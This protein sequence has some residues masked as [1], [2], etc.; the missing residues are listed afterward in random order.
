MYYSETDKARELIDPKYLE[1]VVFDIGSGD[2]K[3]KPEAFG[4]DGRELNGVSYHLK[5]EDAIYN[6]KNILDWGIADCIYSSHLLEHLRK[7]YEAILDW[8]HIIKT[9][10]YLILYLP[11]GRYYSNEGNEEHCRDYTYESFLMFFKRCFCGGGKNYKGESFK[12]IFNLVHSELDIR[13]D[14]Y[15]FL[16]IAQKV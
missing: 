15:S 3:I 8:K 6:L 1:G 9:G 14:C 13:L 12:K 5:D 10:G 11:D 7:D 16:L 2:S 4:V